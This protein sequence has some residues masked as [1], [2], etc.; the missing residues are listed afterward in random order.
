MSKKK[1][2]QQDPGPAK[3]SIMTKALCT[4]IQNLKLY[5]PLENGKLE[6]KIIS[7]GRQ[8]EFSLSTWAQSGMINCYEN[9]SPWNSTPH[10][11]GVKFYITCMVSKLLYKNF[12]LK[13]HEGPTEPCGTQR[14]PPK[15][16][17]E[18]SGFILWILQLNIYLQ[19]EIREY[20]RIKQQAYP[21][22]ELDSQK[23][24]KTIGKVLQKPSLK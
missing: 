8:Q 10:G 12:I 6:G 16:F 21:M 9:I 18:E 22:A 19:S 4:E 3:V 13:V 1:D 7:T 23:L 17:L 20:L 11:F 14:K 2:R 15:Y 24:D 5:N